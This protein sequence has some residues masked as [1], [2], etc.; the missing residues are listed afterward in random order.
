MS[1]LAIRSDI[2]IFICAFLRS[3]ERTEVI[4]ADKLFI[5]Y[6][7]TSLARII[8]NMTLFDVAEYIPEKKSG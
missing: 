6:I 4:N 2:C 7:L 8:L 5:F 1:E 3:M